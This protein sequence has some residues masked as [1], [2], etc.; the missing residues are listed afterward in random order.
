MGWLGTA[1]LLLGTY[2]IGRKLASGWVLSIAG[3]ACWL[4]VGVSRQQWGLVAVNTAFTDLAAW[5]L[6]AWLRPGEGK[7]GNKGDKHAGGV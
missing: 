5:N 4:W 2:C 6:A 7:I 3:Q 1:F